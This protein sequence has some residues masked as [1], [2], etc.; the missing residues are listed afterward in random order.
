MKT[1]YLKM[2]LIIHVRF[3]IYKKL[4]SRSYWKKRK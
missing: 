4:G 1:I 2:Y 3:L